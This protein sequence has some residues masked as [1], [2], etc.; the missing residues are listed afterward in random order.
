MISVRELAL[1][2]FSLF[3]CVTCPVSA[4]NIVEDGEPKAEIVLGVEASKS[5]RRAA[6]EIRRAIEIM[7]GVTLP[8]TTAAATEAKPFRIVIGTPKTNDIIKNDEDLKRRLSDDGSTGQEYAMKS[9]ETG[10]LLA[11]SGEVGALYAAYDFLERLGVRWLWPGETGEFIPKQETIQVPT[12]D[13]FTRPA[14]KRRGFRGRYGREGGVWM[15]RNRLNFGHREVFRFQEIA[16]ELGFETTWGGHSFGWIAPEDCPPVK[17]DRSKGIK[18]KLARDVYCE[19]YP[20]HFSLVK[21]KRAMRQHCYSNPEVQRVF[22][23]WIKRFW[24]S[25]PET[26]ILNLAPMDNPDFCE[27]AKCAEFADDDGSRLHKF[28]NIVIAGVEK[29]FPGKTYRTYA[30]SSYKDAPKGP[31]NPN[32]IVEYCMYDRCYKHALHDENCPVN[33]QALKKFDAWLDKDVAEY[34]MYGYHYDALT[35]KNRGVL[36]P[37]VPVIQDELK[38]LKKEEFTSF[39]SELGKA[40]AFSPDNLWAA[41]QI[42]VYIVGKLMWDPNQDA[43]AILRDACETVYGPAAKPMTHYHQLTWKA[44]MGD[45]HVSGYFRNPATVADTFL[46]PEVIKEA[47]AI[48]AEAEKVLTDAPATEENTRSEKNLLL[49]KEVYENWRDIASTKLSW[50]RIAEEKNEERVEMLRNAEPKT[51]LFEMD[52]ENVQPGSALAGFAETTV[53]EN[54]P[55]S[56]NYLAFSKASGDSC[57]FKNTHKNLLTTFGNYRDWINYEACLDFRFPTGASNGKRFFALITRRCGARFLRPFR[58]YGFMVSANTLSVSVRTLKGEP[59]KVKNG[60]VKFRDVGLGDLTTGQWYSLRVRH[61]DGKL[62][63]WLGPKGEKETS[64][65]EFDVPL[66][67]GGINLLNFGDLD[68]DNLAVRKLPP[69]DDPNLFSKQFQNDQPKR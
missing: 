66:G 5:E 63:V 51:T 43:A 10:I 41:N 22:I 16:A 2:A 34:S 13:V 53:V 4:T 21:G 44:W 64:L 45:G 69:I 65:G 58:H 55:E 31:V 68:L 19:K 23:D 20:E 17:P 32:L 56:G 6:D 60:V 57:L 30:Y 12:L 25:H 14:F 52:F 37:L 62:F 67:G 38:L 39:A 36:L 35:A 11:G 7:S 18:G 27:C 9:N 48:F 29:E 24:R 3:L 46:T 28:L 1:I 15:A 54:D 26:N 8:I 42:G 61:V 47:D 40:Y 33:R 49:A 59:Y 50:N